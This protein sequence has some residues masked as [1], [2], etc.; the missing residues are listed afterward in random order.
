[1]DDALESEEHHFV[2]CE[3]AKETW[4]GVVDCLAERAP[5]PAACKMFFDTVVQS[6]IWHI[7]RYRDALKTVWL[8]SY[9]ADA[10]GGG[11]VIEMTGIKQT[12]S[13]APLS[14]IDP[15]TSSSY[16]PRLLFC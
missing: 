14:T 1:K 5:V 4:R 16:V 7:W 8:P 12:R 11:P 15:G 6:T 3:L 13:Y 2:Y 9:T 10:S